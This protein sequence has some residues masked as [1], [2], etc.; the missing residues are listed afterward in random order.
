MPSD[1]GQLDLS[2]RP[3]YARIIIEGYTAKG[4][5][6]ARFAKEAGIDKSFMNRI[7]GGRDIPGNDLLERFAEKL[8]F[9][10]HRTDTLKRVAGAEF[11]KRN[12]EEADRQDAWLKFHM[13]EA[14]AD[15][16][17]RKGIVPPEH[18]WH[19]YADELERVVKYSNA[20]DKG[21]FLTVDKA[22]GRQGDGVANQGMQGGVQGNHKAHRSREG[23]AFHLPRSIGESPD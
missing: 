5:S 13:V 15:F 1:A 17:S 11:A 22:Y 3:E 19:D 12:P 7:V 18:P 20:H 16:H 6:Q 21:E 2:E 23:R 8:G 14:Y 9:D 10:I 4:W